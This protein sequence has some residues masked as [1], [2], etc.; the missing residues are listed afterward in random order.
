MVLLIKTAVFILPLRKKLL[1]IV[2]F[3]CGDNVGDRKVITNG[4][5]E[6]RVMNPKDFTPSGTVT[7]TL[8]DIEMNELATVEYEV[9]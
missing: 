9:E 5:G 6:Y 8:Y 2:R 1:N 4:A 7:A 3:K